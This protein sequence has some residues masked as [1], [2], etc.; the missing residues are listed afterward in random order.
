V[1]RFL[2][3]RFAGF[4]V[5]DWEIWVPWSLGGHQIYRN[6]S[7]AWAREQ[8]P[9]WG[10]ER[11]A[12]EA[13]A[14]WNRT[15]LEF[16]AH[17]L[18]LCTKL[19][20]LARW[21]YYGRPGCYTGV[22]ATGDFGCVASVQ[23]RN[24]ALLPL[25]AASTALFPSVYDTPSAKY[26]LEHTARYVSSEIAE[27]LRLR[28][29]LGRTADSMPVAAYTWPDLFVSDTE[30]NPFL[31]GSQMGVEF[32]TPAKIG[33]DVVIVWGGASDVHSAERCTTFSHYFHDTLAPYLRQ[34]KANSPAKLD[35]EG[36][37]MHSRYA[38]GTHR[39]Q[40]RGW[41]HGSCLAVAL[42]ALPLQWRSMD[43]ILKPPVLAICFTL[44]CSTI[45][46]LYPFTSVFWED[47]VTRM[48]RAS[49]LI[50]NLASFCTPQL[51]AERCRPPLSYTLLTVV[52]PN[53]VG[54]AFI[55]RGAKHPAV[56]TG[57]II[58]SIATAA[59]WLQQDLVLFG[60]CCCCLACYGFGMLVF[61]LRLGG[62]NAT[63]WG[64]HEHF[65]LLIVV[66]FVFNVKGIQRLAATCSPTS[67]D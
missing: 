64:Y 65:H 25:W 11:V 22:A 41:L 27:A 1:E 50:I 7:L 42:A 62:R 30:P 20:P 48:D 29:K 34:L 55:L 5:I 19:R 28:K 24:D 60:L 14:A 58:A 47:R 51:T 40:C 2:P 44:L 21:G 54:L 31:N 15:A 16:M 38:D 8:N 12:A 13:S 46:H 33:A 18:G 26:P 17:T 3:P 23:Q 59:F 43:L 63:R 45:C 32:S 56:F 66:G 35:D 67:Y 37:L 57:S 61:I 4:A 53:L 10:P 9:T 36:A 6:E 39:P 49:I 52:V